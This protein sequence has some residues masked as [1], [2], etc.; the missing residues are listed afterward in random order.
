MKV[1][2][3]S[4]YQDLSRS[5]IQDMVILTLNPEISENPENPEIPEI[6]IEILKPLKNPEKNLECKIRKS[7]RSGLGFESPRKSRKNHE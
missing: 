2:H 3:K 4:S 7:R 1:H 6:G 5:K